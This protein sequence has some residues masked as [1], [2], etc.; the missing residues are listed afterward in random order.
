MEKQIVELT[1]RLAAMQAK[2]EAL[3]STL[4]PL[5]QDSVNRYLDKAKERELKNLEASD[6]DLIELVEQLYR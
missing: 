5:H 2:I 4:S 3:R 1:L 6:S